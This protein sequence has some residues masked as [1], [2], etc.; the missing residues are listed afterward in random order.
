M[1][2]IES[3]LSAVYSADQVSFLQNEIQSLIDRYEKQ[4]VRTEKEIDETDVCLITY[5]DQLSGKGK[6]KL[7]VLNEFLSNHLSEISIVHILPFYPYSSDDGFSV[8]DYY[9]VNE[10]LGS[11]EN[12]EELAKDKS[13]MFDA[14]INHISQHSSWFKGFLAN[15]A[16]YADYFIQEDPR[17]SFSEV[18]RPRVT[19]LLH[20]FE[21]KNGAIR[22]VWTTFSRDQVDLNYKNPKVLLHILDVLL[23]YLA[24]G[25]TLLRLDAIGFMWKKKGTT[26]IH[27]DETHFLIKVIREILCELKPNL[28]LITETNVPHLENISYFG[29]G[30]DEA[31][32][33]YNFTL[34]PLLAFSL[35]T[36][37]ANKLFDW[38]NSLEL[39]SDKVC[40]FNFTASHDG[41]GVRP[42]QGILKE[43]EVQIIVDAAKANDGLVS[44][45]S[46]SDGS[47]S[48]YEINCNYFSLLHGPES[49]AEVGLRRFL[50]SQVFVLAI[51]GLPA[52]Y[53]HSMVGSKNYREGVEIT[54]QNRTINRQKLEFDML[55]SEL[56]DKTSE[57][58][59]VF[60]ELKRMIGIRSTQKAFNPYGKFNFE[61]ISAQV[62]LIEREVNGDKIYCLF[63]FSHNENQIDFQKA[64]SFTNLIDNK[65]YSSSIIMK[66]LS[67]LWLKPDA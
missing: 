30:R 42:V 41:V 47:Q 65:Q 66:P 21:D 67:Y 35:L 14:V 6:S 16:E 37:N 44:Y 17:Y 40:F 5:G 60:E 25:A 53:F 11:W 49:D 63:N 18:V 39:P 15:E 36:G 55:I 31:H 34:P 22:H 20:D 48:P 29:N 64:A 10:E 9:S 12:I 1:K 56:Q 23:W 52:I 38:A 45:K 61:K 43:E 2:N 7:H 8:I 19:P 26:S 4:I 62:L 57:R 50:L 51:P 58:H 24:K 32:M 33:V 46:N 28:T 59:K 13:L 54:N 3:Y 27:L